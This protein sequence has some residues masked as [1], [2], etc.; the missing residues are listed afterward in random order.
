MKTNAITTTTPSTV[1]TTPA[2]LRPPKADVF[3]GIGVHKRYSV[4]HVLDSDGLELAKGRIDHAEPE[5]FADLV[6]R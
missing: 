6:R 4:Y 1:P 5:D 3:T 2:S